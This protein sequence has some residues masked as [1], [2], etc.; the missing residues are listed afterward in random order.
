MVAADAADSVVAEAEAAAAVVVEA[1]AGA[2][3]RS[4]FLS[5]RRFEKN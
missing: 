3:G 1:G 2:T 4:H 5:G